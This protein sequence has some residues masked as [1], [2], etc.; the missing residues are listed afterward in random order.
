MRLKVQACRDRTGHQAIVQRKPP[1]Q[2]AFTGLGSS[3]N[4]MV[5]FIFSPT[6]T[7]ERGFDAEKHLG[8]APD[9]TT[10]E[11]VPGGHIGLFTGSRTLRQAWTT[12]A[13]WIF[14]IG[15]TRPRDGHTA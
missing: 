3:L 12:V 13:R 8:F 1:D 4:L 14:S 10:K 6:S 7:K 15:G 5:P 2:G 9:R 11:L